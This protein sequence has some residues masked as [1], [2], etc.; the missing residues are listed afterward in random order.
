MGV[1]IS[2]RRWTTRAYLTRC[3]HCRWAIDLWSLST[4]LHLFDKPSWMQ[5]KD[6]RRDFSTIKILS[7]ILFSIRPPTYFG[8][9]TKHM[10]SDFVPSLPLFIRFTRNV[11]NHVLVCA[12]YSAHLTRIVDHSRGLPPPLLL[13][14]SCG[15]VMAYKWPWPICKAGEVARHL[16]KAAEKSSGINQEIWATSQGRCKVCQCLNSVL[17]RLEQWLV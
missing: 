12:A 15:A 9:E 8:S 16:R 17:W 11:F 6:W 3:F 2:V 14:T 5:G 10:Q 7:K 1:G 13:G 4:S